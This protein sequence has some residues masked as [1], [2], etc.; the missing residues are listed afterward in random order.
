MLRSG[1]N[2]SLSC[3]ADGLPIPNIQWFKDG[4]L[5]QTELNDR[6]FV[7]E[8]VVLDRVY[9]LAETARSTLTLFELNSV[10]SGEYT[11][12]AYNEI[13]LVA[14]LREPYSLIVPRGKLYNLSFHHNC[15]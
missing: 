6:L 3:T 8:E 12:R 13:G 5:L 10:D 11:C 9:N 4:R 2:I 7:T 14:V 1:G 15:K